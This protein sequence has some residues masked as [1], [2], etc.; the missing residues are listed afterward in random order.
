[1]GGA[2][3]K[4]MKNVVWAQDDV[5]K[6]TDAGYFN[7]TSDYTFDP[8]MNMTRAMFFTVIARMAGVDTSSG[9]EWY[10]VGMRWS[11]E[12]AITDG[13]RP[14]DS[15][16]REQIVTMLYR[17]SVRETDEASMITGGIQDSVLD[18][19][20]DVDQISDW[21]YEAMIWA[22]SEGIIRGDENV[23]RNPRALA[24]RAEVAAIISRYGK[25]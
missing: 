7:G 15:I 4:D 10:E 20:G 3:Y 16:T 19:F 21:A 14:M 5:Y 8:A 18:A 11:M 6:V 24:T 25:L 22:V 1:M 23:K 13:T 9:G 12:N 17:Y 2:Y